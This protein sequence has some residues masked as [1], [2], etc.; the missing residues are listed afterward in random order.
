MTARW[1]WRSEGS[2]APTNTFT[3]FRATVELDEPPVDASVGFAADSAAQLRLNGQALRRKVTRLHEPELR[4]KSVQAAPLLRQGRNVG[5][6][7]HHYWGAV[8]TFQRTS[9]AHA[10]LFFDSSWLVSGEGW[11]WKA[12]EE[13]ERH[14]GQ[15]LGLAEAAAR[16]RF[17]VNW[18]AKVAP[19]L[20]AD[21][22]L[23]AVS[24]EGW[25]RGVVVDDGPWPAAREPV[26]TPAQRES[27]QLPLAVLAAGRAERAAD[28][29][30]APTSPSV[31][32]ASRVLPDEA[33]RVHVG[34]LTDRQEVVVGGREG[35]TRYLT[36][37]F[38]RPGH[39]FPFLELSADAAADVQVDL[40]YGEL[41]ISPYDG[42]DLVTED[43]WVDVDGVA[44]RGYSDHLRPATERRRYEFPD[45][46]TARWMTV[47]LTFA[48]EGSVVLHSLGIVKSQYAPRGSFRSGDERLDQIVKLCEIHAEVTMSDAFV[49]IPGREDGQWIEDARPRAQLAERW[50]GDTRL[51]RLAIRTLAEGQRAD[52][53]LHPFFPSNFPAYPAPWDWSVQWVAMLYDDFVWHSDL[54][55]LASHWPTVLRFWDRLLQDVGDDG[56]WRSASVLGD[57]RNSVL[58]QEGT[59]SGLVTPWIIERLRWSADMA[60]A[61]RDARHA[62]M[63]RAAAE[64]MAESFRQLHV[65]R[66][67]DEVSAIVADG[68]VATLVFPHEFHGL[69]L[70]DVDGPGEPFAGSESVT[71]AGSGR[72]TFESVGPLW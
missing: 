18:N 70:Q 30:E 61:L 11:Q 2:L 56:V 39:G 38:G 72:Y 43:G 57:V 49:D 59:S 36:V 42:R 12:A 40:G 6:V 71:L 66:A 60:D 47:H 9:N 13:F 44:A 27:E 17:P 62:S 41:A 24:G 31:L 45:E 37:D 32:A 33:M 3:W 8:T 15:F 55:F 34:G 7:L 63:W 46:R 23:L 22:G 26:E 28:S 5:T 65:V 52:G 69:R 51:R 35:E 16:L 19:D 21:S 10:G 1:V 53:Q 14:D 58:P 67:R 29:G 54:D 20:R 48:A 68:C 64:R 50:Y 4:A 25:E